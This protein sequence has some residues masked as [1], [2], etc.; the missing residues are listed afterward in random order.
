MATVGNHDEIE[1]MINDFVQSCRASG[2]KV[3][4]QRLEIYRALLMSHDHPSAEL[5][6]KRLVEKMPTISMD[7]VYRAM[8]TF[9]QHGLVSR[10]QTAGSLARFE[11]VTTPHHHLIC[12]R[13]NRVADF[14][15]SAF[16]NV[17]LPAPV[18]KW[19]QIVSKNV[20]MYGICNNC[21]R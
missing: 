19:G 12:S 10:I 3:T 7:T 13:C 5:L 18:E 17:E 15:W 14:L 11:A 20:V 2:L 21:Q 4:H 8:A 16:D 9:E 1:A 6:H